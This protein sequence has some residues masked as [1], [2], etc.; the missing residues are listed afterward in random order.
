[1]LSPARSR[2]LC[3]IVVAAILLGL[4]ACGSQTKGKAGGAD[5]SP[6][7]QAGADVSPSDQAGADVSPADQAVD[8]PAMMADVGGSPDHA[9]QPDA[10]DAGD[11]AGTEAPPRAVCGSPG[12]GDPQDCEAASWLKLE[13][14]SLPFAGDGTVARGENIVFS[15][16]LANRGTQ[17]FNS[18]PC[19][20]FVSDHPLIKFQAGSDR[21]QC[22]FAIFAG[23]TA[24][25][26]ATGRVDPNIA[27]GTVVRVAANVA[28]LH[29]QCPS[30]SQVSLAV[31][32]R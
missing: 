6:I 26:S 22:R 1:M 21:C 25:M 11:M 20:A 13:D 18:Y 23:A 12:Q 19:V 7:D 10:A 16:I 15:V 9:V 32:V 2:R 24:E 8:V 3:R 28:P 27:P 30:L 31:T 14:P 5:A 4:A 29:G 17:S